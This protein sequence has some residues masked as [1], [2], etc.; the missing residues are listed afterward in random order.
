[1]FSTPAAGNMPIETYT[2]V[3]DQYRRQINTQQEASLHAISLRRNGALDQG[4]HLWTEF[5][6][7]PVTR[8]LS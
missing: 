7:I 2:D 4:T 5:A 3:K 8:Q 1:V 6:K